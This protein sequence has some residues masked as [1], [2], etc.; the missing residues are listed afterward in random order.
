MNK[1]EAYKLM[2]HLLEMNEELLQLVDDLVDNMDNMSELQRKE[3]KSQIHE[4][5]ERYDD[6]C[7]MQGFRFFL[8]MANESIARIHCSLK[9]VEK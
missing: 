7:C 9:E 4:N 5:Y 1:R 3:I 6:Y 2:K 8:K